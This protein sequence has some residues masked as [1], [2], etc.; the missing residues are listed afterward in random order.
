M[1]NRTCSLL[2]CDKAHRARGLCS[3]HY[4]RAHQPAAHPTYTITCESC[5]QTHATKRSGSRFCSLLC[6]DIW[7]NDG[8]PTLSP[9]PLGHPVMRIYRGLSAQAPAPRVRLRP[10]IRSVDCEWCGEAFN[11]AKPTRRM[12]LPGMQTEIIAC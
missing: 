11:T 8:R 1:A 4:N 3:S 5:G 9:L 10:Q 6:R 12:W 7:R 2:G